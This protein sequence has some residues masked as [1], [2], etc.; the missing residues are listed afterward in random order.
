MSQTSPRNH[1]TDRTWTED[2]GLGKVEDSHTLAKSGHPSPSDPDKNPEGD[3][4]APKG[5]IGPNDP[6]TPALH[7]SVSAR[8]KKGEG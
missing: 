8:G 2:Y 6:V 7:C 1:S 4:V 5:V 3:I